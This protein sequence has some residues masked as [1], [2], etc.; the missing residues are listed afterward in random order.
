MSS[1]TMYDNQK[2]LTDIQNLQR[3][4]TALLNSLESNPNMST[5]DKEAILSKINE[6]SQLRINLY[7]TLSNVN[8]F[9]K[10]ELNVTLD[11]YSQQRDAIQIVE[12]ELNKTKKRL[13]LLNTDKSNKIRLVEINSYY[14]DKYKEHSQLMKI[15]IYTLIPIIVVNIVYKYGLLPYN[16]FIL[17]VIVI[18]IIGSYY[19]WIRMASIMMRDKLNY[20]KYDWGIR[21]PDQKEENVTETPDPW[22]SASSFGTCVGSYCCS[23]GLVYDDIKDMCV[24]ET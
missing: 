12:S 11:S 18:A 14:S 3:T 8:S 5:S 24:V 13:D 9:S 16:I 17:L 2:L 4:E 6:F 20:D 19:F 21:P 1:S 22:F 23:E 15:V 7:R 10:N